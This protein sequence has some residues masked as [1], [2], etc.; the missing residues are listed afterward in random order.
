MATYFLHLRPIVSL[1]PFVIAKA[2]IRKSALLLSG[3]AL[4]QPE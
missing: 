2:K 4:T 3:L 1:G